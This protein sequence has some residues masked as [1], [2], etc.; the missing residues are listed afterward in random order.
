MEETR[1]LLSNVGGIK[2]QNVM[3]LGGPGGDQKPINVDIKGNDIQELKKISNQLMDQ[4]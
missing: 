2:V 4:M 3:P 1:K